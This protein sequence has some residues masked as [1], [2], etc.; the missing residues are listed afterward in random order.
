MSVRCFTADPSSGVS[1]EARGT[2][3]GII[4]KV[5]GAVGAVGAVGGL[6]HQLDVVL[7]G[8]VQRAAASRVMCCVG[9]TRGCC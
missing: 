6:H 7:G 8:I 1:Q 2:Y 5:W 9:S 4:E 3:K